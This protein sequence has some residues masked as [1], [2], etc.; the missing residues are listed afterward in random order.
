[1][2]IYK[3]KTFEKW[4]KKAKI[5]DE[6]LLKAA[7]EVSDGLID[8]KLGRGIY[9]KRI[10]LAGYGKRTSARTIVGYQKEKSMFFLYGFLKSERKNIDKKELKFLRGYIRELFSLDENV[11]HASMKKGEFFEI[12]NNGK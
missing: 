3:I 4:A 12:K 8:A 10:S 6:A 7:L 1:M 5:T 2:K 11:F 9:K